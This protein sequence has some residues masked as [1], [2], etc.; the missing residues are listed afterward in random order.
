MYNSYT[1][2]KALLGADIE[3]GPKPLLHPRTPPDGEAAM[4]Q[5]L[6]QNTL[7]HQLPGWASILYPWVK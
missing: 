4:G 6:G 5:T 1:C 7:G 2:D 3:R